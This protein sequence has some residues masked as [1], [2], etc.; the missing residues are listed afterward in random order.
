MTVQLTLSTDRRADG[1]VVLTA[2]GEIDMSNAG[3][4]GVAVTAALDA[5]AEPLVVDLT[6]VDYIDSAGLACLFPHVERIRLVTG[7]MLA[8]VFTISGLGDLTT[9][10]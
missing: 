10:R 7:P 2:V 3:E 6:A 9:T 4:F 8:P 5:G 1:G